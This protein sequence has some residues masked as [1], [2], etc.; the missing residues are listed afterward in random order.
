MSIGLQFQL[1]WVWVEVNHGETLGTFPWNLKSLVPPT[2]KNAMAHGHRNVSKQFW[3][4]CSVQYFYNFIWKFTN[5]LYSRVRLVT[6]LALH[7]TVINPPYSHTMARWMLLMVTRGYASGVG[8]IHM[9]KKQPR[10]F[11]CGLQVIKVVKIIYSVIWKSY[12]KRGL[13]KNWFKALVWP[14]QKVLEMLQSK[15]KWKK[16]KRRRLGSVVWAKSY[17]ASK[18]I[19]P[20]PLAPN[21]GKNAKQCRHVYWACH[22]Q[23]Q[24]YT[25]LQFLVFEWKRR[26]SCSKQWLIEM[27]DQH[28]F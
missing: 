23:H 11:D 26:T 28:A 9:H 10:H 13:E 1:G 19:I 8:L 18:I 6:G 7:L 12:L 27:G 21:D 25:F 2:N 4:A 22:I 17:Q 20:T 15:K 24:C 3:I 5:S 14:L 16:Y